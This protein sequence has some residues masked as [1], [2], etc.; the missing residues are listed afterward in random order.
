MPD[1]NT[2]DRLVTPWQYL[3]MEYV[4][5]RVDK[6]ERLNDTATTARDP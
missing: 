1:H 3:L 2:P 4:V 5:C 6:T